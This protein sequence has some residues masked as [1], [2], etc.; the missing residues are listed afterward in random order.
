MDEE[1][2]PSAE[3]ALS[4]AERCF[5][6]GKLEE[7]AEWVGYALSFDADDKGAHSLLATLRGAVDE[8]I[9]LVP[10]RDELPYPSRALRALL[11]WESGERKKALSIIF[12]V[13][14]L[15]P[16]AASYTPWAERWLAEAAPLPEFPHRACAVFLHLWLEDSKTRGEDRPWLTA[17][18]ERL[19]GLLEKLAGQE[20]DGLTLQAGA[21][22]LRLLDRPEESRS[23][24]ERAWESDP[25]WR[26][27]V[28]LALALR[29]CGER[30]GALEAYRE[31]LRLRP[32]DLAVRRDLAELLCGLERFAEA[33]DVLE[34]VAV[35]SPE[36]HAAMLYAG[37]LDQGAP[38]S[39][40]KL[41]AL[42]EQ[43]EPARLLVGRLERFEAAYRTWLP[44]PHDAPAPEAEEVATPSALLAWRALGAE[45]EEPRL[46][47]ERLGSLWE[48]RDGR[49][50]CA[51]PPPPEELAEAVASLA[52]EPFHIDAWWAY[53]ASLPEV[54]VRPCLAHIPPPPEGMPAWEWVQRVQLA[55][56]LGLARE[57][58]GRDVLRAL[59]REPPDW[60]V[61]AAVVA[62][63]AAA[64]R[65]EAALSS[66][67]EDF[68][69]LLV[70]S[71]APC[72]TLPLV[73]CSLWFPELP[74][75][76][77]ASLHVLK[78]RLLWYG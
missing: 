34:P 61:G 29:A 65:D 74:E 17:S 50:A 41:R 56:A 57:E 38:A 22:I 36:A 2:G 13:L 67:V 70:H 16:E 31:A 45:G 37:W 46:S 14:A 60:A 8:P 48:L 25:S 35:R 68:R 39:A 55:A 11:L 10:S 76:L 1:Q 47:A 3:E 78:R 52:A 33:R 12:D 75:P 21:R 6:D 42:G 54:D 27:A 59:L 69:R 44:E 40:L 18:E 62:L 63:A 4:Q 24:A 71:R 64:H 20:L 30:E 53:A 49:L 19:P 73:C 66:T 58:E 51:L 9:A 72:Q 28:T 32:D 43:E 23:W 26:S 5:L 77:R 15:W 7:A